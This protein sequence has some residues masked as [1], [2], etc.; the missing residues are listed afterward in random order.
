MLIEADTLTSPVKE[1]R[2]RRSE[3]GENDVYGGSRKFGGYL[4]HIIFDYT[5]ILMLVTLLIAAVF[6]ERKNLFVMIGVLV[7]YLLCIPINAVLHRLTH[8]PN[9]GAVLPIPVAVILVIISTLL[10][11]I[12]GII[13]SRSAAKKDP[14]VALRT[15]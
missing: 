4:R 11:L 2:K 7:T 6:D 12:A 14:V 15:E 1:I 13:P 5:S 3:D 9:L 8:I 10:T